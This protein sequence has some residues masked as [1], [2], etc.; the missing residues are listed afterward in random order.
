MSEIKY[1]TKRIGSLDQSYLECG[2][3]DVLLLIHGFP[4]HS[5]MWRKMMP[6]L[7]KNFRVIAPD[8]RGMGGTTITDGGYEKENLARDMEKFLNALEIDKINLVGY[9][10]GGGVAYSFASQFSDRVKKAC[11]I[12]YV[13]PG[14]GYEHGL[15]PVRNWQAWQL[16][17]FTV[18]DVAIQFIAGKEREL[19]AWYFWHWS[20]NPDAVSQ[21]DFE[22]Y[23]RNLQKPGALRAGFAHF[24]AVFD[25]T[26]H[27]KVTAKVKLD[28]PVLA[29]GGEMGA[30]EFMVPGWEQ[31]ANDVTGS[32]VAECGHWIAD[33]QPKLLNRQL[34]DFF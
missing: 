16:A 29:L 26:E 32:V 19:L 10:H 31:L 12:E 22:N 2:T 28:M 21:A 1:H 24:A 14:F 18:P 23:V 20:Y 8:L 5:H 3:G 17:F 7:S 33:E 25:D 34:L 27:F 15:Q 9:D 13:P 30:G 4:Q 11:F 6:E